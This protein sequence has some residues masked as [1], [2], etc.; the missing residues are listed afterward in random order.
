MP[1]PAVVMQMFVWS[2]MEVD[3]PTKA[4]ADAAATETVKP[5]ILVR[6]RQINLLMFNLIT[7]VFNT[8]FKKHTFIDIF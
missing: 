1:L 5:V 4:A 8:Q 7:C 2:A 6:L 3:E